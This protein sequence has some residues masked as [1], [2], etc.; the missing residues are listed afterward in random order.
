MVKRLVGVQADGQGHRRLD[1]RM[2]LVRRGGDEDGGRLAGGHTDIGT[3]AAATARTGVDGE[4]EWLRRFATPGQRRDGQLAAVF[5]RQNQDDLV[6][7]V[8]PAVHDLDTGAR[9]AAEYVEI[10]VQRREVGL[11]TTAAL[12]LQG[13]LHRLA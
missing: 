13:E 10:L 12:V 7:R 3:P 9:A 2:F 5:R 11:A 6:L 4:R 8:H 1:V